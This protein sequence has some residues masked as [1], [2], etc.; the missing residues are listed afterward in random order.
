[1]NIIS[2][3]QDWFPWLKKISEDAILHIFE[4]RIPSQQEVG[5]ERCKRDFWKENMNKINMS[6][7]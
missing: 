5:E 1:M 6:T 2:N 4:R 3:E 7:K